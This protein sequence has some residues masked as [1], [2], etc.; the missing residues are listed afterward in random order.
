[1][2]VPTTILTIYHDDGFVKSVRDHVMSLNE[3]YCFV[4]D[5]GFIL[6]AYHVD[7]NSAGTHLRYMKNFILAHHHI[8]YIDLDSEIDNL[9][10]RAHEETHFF[11]F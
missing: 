2:V 10:N 9:A 7:K 6:G 8:C 1:M 11:R 5:M 3:K 4:D